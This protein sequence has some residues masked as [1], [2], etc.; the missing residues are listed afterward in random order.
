[1]SCA[2]MRSSR[3]EIASSRESRYEVVAEMVEEVEAFR[4]CECRGGDEN[5]MIDCDLGGNGSML[6][7][8]P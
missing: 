7:G 2:D 8:G 5:G 6:E 1:M 4:K 3:V